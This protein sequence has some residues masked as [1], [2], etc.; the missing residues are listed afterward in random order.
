[1]FRSS[2][3]RRVV[4]SLAALSFLVVALCS[5]VAPQKMA[6]P[7]GYQL[8]RPS[9]LNEYRAIYVGLFLAHA[10]VLLWAARRVEQ[11]VLGD[12]AGLLIL[13]SP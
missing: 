4:L 9:A 8:T 12:V 11:A 2:V 7:F 1:M 10:L 13:R 3:V 6:E 5:L